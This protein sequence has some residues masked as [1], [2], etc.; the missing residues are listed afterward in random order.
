[1]KT[2]TE[3]RGLREERFGGRGREWRMRTRDRAESRQYTSL[4]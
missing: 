3:T 4:H 2:E 1:M